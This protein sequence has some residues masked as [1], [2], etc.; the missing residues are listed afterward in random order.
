M[1]QLAAA[2]QVVPDDITVKVAAGCKKYPPR[3]GL[4]QPEGEPH[5]FLRL[6]PAWQ[7]KQ[8]DRYTFALAGEP[9]AQRGRLRSRIGRIEQVQHLAFE[10]RGRQ[11]VGDQY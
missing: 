5:I 1:N 6:R 2:A 10:M 4:G 8:I 9:L 7:Q 3:G 11:A